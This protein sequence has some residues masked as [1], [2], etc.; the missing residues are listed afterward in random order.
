MEL[1]RI[2]TVNDCITIYKASLGGLHQ[3]DNQRLDALDA[4]MASITRGALRQA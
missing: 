1:V 3:F 4:A 2:V